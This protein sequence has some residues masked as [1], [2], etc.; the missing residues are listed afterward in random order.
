MAKHAN[1]VRKDILEDMKAGNI[2]PLEDET[3]AGSLEFRT[4]IE[5][6]FFDKLGV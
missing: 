2:F 3:D 6:T 5:K 4:I 1:K